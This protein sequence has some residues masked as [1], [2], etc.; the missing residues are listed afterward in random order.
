METT[1]GVSLLGLWDCSRPAIG[2]FEVRWD[3]AWS[4]QKDE[5]FDYPFCDHHEGKASSMAAQFA[6]CMRDGGGNTI[7][8]VRITRII[9][10]KV[11]KV[12][13][14]RLLPSLCSKEF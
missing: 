2:A 5:E 12:E 3:N 7:F 1:C 10:G 13:G 4:G 8:N 14:A 6:G 9:E 11:S